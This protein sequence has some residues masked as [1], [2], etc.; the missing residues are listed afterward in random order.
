MLGVVIVDN[1]K[2]H[3]EKARL[4]CEANGVR[5]TGFADAMA[6]LRA[7]IFG[8][9][10]VAVIDLKQTGCDGLDIIR[11]AVASSGASCV[12]AMTGGVDL[13]RVVAAMRAGAVDVLPKPISVG[14]IVAAAKRGGLY[15]DDVGQTETETVIDRLTRRERQVLDQLRK[16]VST[17]A[18]ADRLQVSV[19]TVESHKSKLYSKFGV[20]SHADLIRIIKT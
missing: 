7:P 20:R 10:H 14:D 15:S 5:A 16:G 9:P 2:A 8:D 11:S 6:Y 12:F 18:I 17:K 19:R 3:L 1:E 13:P 4:L